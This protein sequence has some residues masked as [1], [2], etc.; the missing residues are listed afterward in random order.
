MKKIILSAAAVAI[1]GIS[2]TKASTITR[3]YIST[4]TIQ[5]DSTQKATVKLTDLPEAVKTTLTSDEFKEWIPSAAFLVKSK[6]AEYY[7]VQVTKGQETKAVKID[8]YG[9][10]VS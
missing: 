10:P 2:A 5:Q 4:N 3:P 6:D 7:E 9:K 8:K 1:L